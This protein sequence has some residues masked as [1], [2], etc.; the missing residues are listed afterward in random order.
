MRKRKRPYCII[1]SFAVIPKYSISFS[2]FPDFPNVSLIPNLSNFTGYS[3]T[4]TSAIAE[5]N[6]P[7]ILWSSIDINFFVSFAHFTTSS[8]S[9]G[10]IV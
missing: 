5:P 1:I 6:P 3:S 9:I 7:I 4:S 10:F 8:L 2:A